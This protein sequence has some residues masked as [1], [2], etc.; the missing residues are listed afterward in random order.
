MLLLLLDFIIIHIMTENE[1]L[2]LAKEYN[3]YIEKPRITGGYDYK[4]LYIVSLS[5]TSPRALMSYMDECPPYCVV[6]NGN[7]SYFTDVKKAKI[8]LLKEIIK[9]KQEAI[10]EKL[11][12]SEK[13]F[14]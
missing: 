4:Y 12:N 13:D 6:Y 1:F 10:K 8:E 5:S 7:G 3:L 9:R 14:V 2:N 11:K